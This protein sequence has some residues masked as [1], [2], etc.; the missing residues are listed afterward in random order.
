M[1]EQDA[2][3][4]LRQRGRRAAGGGRAGEGR[5]A[6]VPVHQGVLAGRER[7][8]DRQRRRGPRCEGPPDYLLAHL[9]CLLA[10]LPG[11]GRHDERL[12]GMWVCCPYVCCTDSLPTWE[13]FQSKCAEKLGLDTSRLF[14][15][16][17]EVLRRTALGIRRTE[18]RSIEGRQA[19][20]ETQAR[21]RHECGC[22]SQFEPDL[23]KLW[24]VALLLHHRQTCSAS[25]VPAAC[26][27]R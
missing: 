23:L 26:T 11:Q 19:G 17:L 8:E 13:A 21:P 16:C 25:L 12:V 9:I 6:V 15:D 4:R 1:A 14:I 22:P 10:C 24:C 18:I 27:W 5:A 3:V 2:G 7:D 20:R